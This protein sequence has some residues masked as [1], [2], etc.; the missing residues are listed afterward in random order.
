MPEPREYWAFISYRHLA[1]SDSENLQLHR[2]LLQA[3]NSE[4]LAFWLR[5]ELPEAAR[6]YE[7]AEAIASSIVERLPEPNFQSRLEWAQ[8]LTNL[9]NI[10]TA[11]GRL[12]DAL[13][14]CRA[15]L[16]LVIET[17][18]LG[19]VTPEFVAE[20]IEQLEK[21]IADLEQKTSTKP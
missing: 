9:T 3:I 16:E 10:A 8:V 20:Q 18:D 14:W 4:A 2:N 21:Q 12:D 19:V 11:A 5:E 17:R 6:R 13:R 7:Q 15:W 1:D